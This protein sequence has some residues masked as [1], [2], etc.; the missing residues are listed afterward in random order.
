MMERQQ[1]TLVIMLAI[2][3][4]PIRPLLA[5]IFNR[6]TQMAMAFGKSSLRPTEKR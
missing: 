6:L 5:Q 4:L 2:K 3:L 1:A